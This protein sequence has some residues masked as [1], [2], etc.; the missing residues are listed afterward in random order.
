M[1]DRRRGDRLAV[2]LSR[3]DAILILLLKLKKVVFKMSDLP[4]VI[5]AYIAAYNRKDMDG[6][7]ACLADTIRFRNI[8]GGEVNA[9]ARDKAGFAEMAAFGASAFK[10]RN[11]TVT[12]AITVADTTLIE[13]DYTATVATDLPNGWKAGQELA[14]SG[15]SAFRIEDGKIVSIVDES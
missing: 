7:L 12:H 15:A 9:E 8:S 3:E 4:D 5:E 10:T 6:M 14:F 13:I 1:F 2:S 11:Q